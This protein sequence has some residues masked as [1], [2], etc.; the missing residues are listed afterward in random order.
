[1]IALNPYAKTSDPGLFRVMLALLYQIG[2]VA[3]AAFLTWQHWGK[4][5]AVFNCMVQ[6]AADLFRAFL[7]PLYWLVQYL[8]QAL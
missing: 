7:W 5:S 3:T 6:V 1:M 8:S 4:C 2:V